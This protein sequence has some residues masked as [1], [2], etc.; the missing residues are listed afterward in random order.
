MPSKGKRI[1][2]RQS[3]L[4]RR[5]SA[6]N[7]NRAGA[8]TPAGPGLAA[9]ANPGSAPTPAAAPAS[10]PAPDAP[11]AGAPTP[12]AASAQPTG[13]PQTQSRG[14]RFDRPAAYNHVGSELIRIGIFSGILL[15]A[16]ITISFLI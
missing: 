9:V 16:L 7:P 10:A 14:R 8:P 13:R 5:R 1:A 6:A 4:R 12:A 2:S 11:P 3:S 15:A